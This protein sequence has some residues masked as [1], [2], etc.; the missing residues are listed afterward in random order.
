MATAKEQLDYLADPGKS[1]YIA[2]VMKASDKIS[3][4]A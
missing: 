2:S 1:C 4:D 3:R